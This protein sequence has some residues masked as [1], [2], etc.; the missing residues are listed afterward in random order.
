MPA[1]ETT[2][3]RISQVA[4]G[5]TE[6]REL[7]ATRTEDASEAAGQGRYGGEVYRDGMCDDQPDVQ[8]AV[9]AHLEA[10]Q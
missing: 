2:P 10:G 3:H 1:S 9:K 7:C 8:A 4:E 5:L 6:A